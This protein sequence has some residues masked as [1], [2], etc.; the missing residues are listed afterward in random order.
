MD[1]LPLIGRGFRGHPHDHGGCHDI[2]AI[3]RED[4]RI[5]LTLLDLIIYMARLR[6]R[7]IGVKVLRGRASIVATFVGL[8]G[9]MGPSS[10]QVFLVILCLFSGGAWNRIG[11]IL[12]ASRRRHPI[13]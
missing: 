2:L 5:P 9:F 1:V 6:P 8:I 7:A 11:I 12:C 13:L 4:R 3:L 10:F